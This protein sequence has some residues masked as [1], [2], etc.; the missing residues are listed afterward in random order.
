[1]IQI[2]RRVALFRGVDPVRL[3]ALL[4]HKGADP[5]AP[6][7]PAVRIRFHPLFIEGVDA[8]IFLVLEGL[9]Q[10]AQA[11]G[12]GRLLRHRALFKQLAVA[13]IVVAHNDVQ[14]I[15]LATGALNQ[16]DVSGMQRV[17]LTKYHANAFLP[18]RKLQP[19]KPVQRFQLLRAGAFNFRV[20]QLAQIAFCHPAGVGYLL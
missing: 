12:H 10:P 1:M 14:L 13:G 16:I 2:L 11:I 6:D 20:Q 19:E 18:T 8:D 9:Q 3:N 15:D 7:V 5:A 4:V 17:K